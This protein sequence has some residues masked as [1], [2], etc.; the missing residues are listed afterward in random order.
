[1]EKCVVCGGGL[2]KHAEESDGVRLQGWKCRNCG[3][4]FFSSSEMLRW[5]VLT[6]RRKPFV[7]RVRTVGNSKVVTLPEKILQ[8][9]RVHDND[10]VLFDQT[11]AGLLLRIFHPAR[12]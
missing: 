7:R 9:T 1:M 12:S 5:E 11:P 6:G 8:K 10:L 4:T 3:E 2:E